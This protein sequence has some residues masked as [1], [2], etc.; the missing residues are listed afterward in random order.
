M[1]S[2]TRVRQLFKY[3]WAAPNTVLGLLL[4]TASGARVHIH[5]GVIEAEGPLLA[6]A[7]KNLTLIGAAAIT[8][9]HV[10]L[11]T[12][13]AALVHTRAH[14]RV[15]VRQYE[16][17]GPLF[18]PLYLLASFWAGIRGQHPYFDNAFEREAEGG[19]MPV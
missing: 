6:W 4:A 15:H 8:F 5:R 19:S 12:D 17:W 10:V 2:R 1:C 18:I 16:R 11:A 13:A 14:E 9:G 3:L 7:L